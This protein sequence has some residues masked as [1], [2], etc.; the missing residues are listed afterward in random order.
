MISF[1]TCRQ[2]EYSGS[3]F[4]WWEE[5]ELCSPSLFLSLIQTD[6]AYGKVAS[7]V[8]V[9]TQYLHHQVFLSEQKWLCLAFSA[10]LATPNLCNLWD[11]PL[12]LPPYGKKTIHVHNYDFFYW[13]SCLFHVWCGWKKGNVKLEVVRVDS[14]EQIYGDLTFKKSYNNRI[15]KCYCM[16]IY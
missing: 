14:L 5:V 2:P 16:V 6:F 13:T 4:V 15:L 12:I 10:T 3:L 9:L 1:Y 11:K 7:H 8:Y